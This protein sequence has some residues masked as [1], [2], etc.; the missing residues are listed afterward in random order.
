M[1]V[2]AAGAARAASHRLPLRDP[3]L[4]CRWRVPPDPICVF[5]I[6]GTC[7]AI[8]SMDLLTGGTF[9]WRI[10]RSRDNRVIIA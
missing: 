9:A 10:A 4:L 6:D 7:I 5:I 2:I 8:L 3:V 1:K